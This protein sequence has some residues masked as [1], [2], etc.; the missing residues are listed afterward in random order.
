MAGP[1]PRR[2]SLQPGRTRLFNFRDVADACERS[3]VRLRRGI[4]YRS[5]GLNHC[6]SEARDQIHEMGIRRVLDL[7]TDREREAFGVFA[8]PD[9][10]TV[11]IPMLDNHEA[12]GQRFDDVDGDP[13]AEFYLRLACI[14]SAAVALSLAEIVT[15][16]LD[17]EPVAVHCT[18]GKDRTG[19]VTA[20]VLA[21]LGVDEETIAADY[22]RSVTAIP[23]VYASYRECYGQTP[24]DYLLDR[25]MNPIRIHQF[26]DAQPTT[27]RHFLHSIRHQFGSVP[28]YLLWAGVDHRQLGLLPDALR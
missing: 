18:G 24:V 22:A 14:N 21:V 12:A 20:L 1:S 16:A 3:P 28:D 2:T 13:L 15:S 7:R 17:D 19:V 23:R 5:D 26:L 11:H 27:I 8:H 4:L 6:S 9:I 10:V 25:G